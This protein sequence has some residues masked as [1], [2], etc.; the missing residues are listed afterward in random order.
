M[1][2]GIRDK[3]K[4]K[5]MEKENYSFK[6]AFC[7]EHQCDLEIIVNAVEDLVATAVS[8]GNSSQHYAE[9]QRAKAAFVEDLI[10]R[11]EK[12]RIIT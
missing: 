9:L 8:C 6:E 5:K 1:N 10:Q 3:I 7:E 2:M 12:Y 4:I 11:T